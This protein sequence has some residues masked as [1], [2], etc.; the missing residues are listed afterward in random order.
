LYTG[1]CRPELDL[2]KYKPSHNRTDYCT[3]KGRSGLGDEFQ[4]GPKVRT[5]NCY[6]RVEACLGEKP[7]GFYMIRPVFSARRGEPTSS[8]VDPPRRLVIVK[9]V[10]RRVPIW[11]QHELV[12]FCIPRFRLGS[13]GRHK[14]YIKLP[15]RDRKQHTNV[16]STAEA[17]VESR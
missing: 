2:V 5:A 9:G 7:C 13:A 6:D 10:R 12:R 1:K 14:K 8:S 4:G 15:C 3:K 16:S 11:Y 17:V